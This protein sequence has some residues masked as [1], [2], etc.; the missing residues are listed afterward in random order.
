MM[1]IIS[2]DGVISDFMIGI[3][4]K[5]FIYKRFI[6]TLNL[7]YLLEDHNLFMYQAD[8]EMKITIK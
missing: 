4:L 7:I 5:R 3:V 6:W 1:I 2:I 8:Y